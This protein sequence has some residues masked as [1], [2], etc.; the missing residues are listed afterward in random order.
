MLRVS[1][2]LG[3]RTSWKF[4]KF[5]FRKKNTSTIVFA[6]SYRNYIDL[7]YEY[8]MNTVWIQYDYRENELPKFSGSPDPFFDVS[9]Y[10]S[11]R[12]LL[13]VF[14]KLIHMLNTLKTLFKKAIFRKGNHQFLLYCINVFRFHLGVV[15]KR[16]KK[17]HIHMMIWKLY[18]T[19]SATADGQEG[20]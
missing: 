5:K 19:N 14:Q 8:S 2:F 18:A 16:W 12:L 13:R 10:F 4:G 20:C 9:K 11:S 1:S 7:Q 3:V 17:H 6:I 15:W